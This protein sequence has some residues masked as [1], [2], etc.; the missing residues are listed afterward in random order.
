MS[1]RAEP[2]DSRLSHWFEG[3]A[4]REGHVPQLEDALIGGRFLLY[5]AYRLRFFA[6]R[7]AADTGVHVV[8][9]LF[10]YAI[11]R[12]S[13]LYAVV[14]TFAAAAIVESFWWGGL[15]VLRTRVRTLYQAG[16]PRQIPR[17]VGSWLSISAILS[18]IIA[19]GGAVWIVTSALTQR[20]G[21]TP[22]DLYMLSIVAGLAAAV[23]TRCYHSGI[24]AIRRIYRPFSVVI[25]VEVG[26]FALALALWPVVG[27]WSFPIAVTASTAISSA[28]VLRYTRRAYSFL[29]FHPEECMSLTG[30]ARLRGARREF[31]FA[32]LANTVLEMDSFL[33]LA[34][35]IA[36]GGLG[37]PLFVVFFAASPTV[38][39][40]ASWT[41][42]FYF[43]L[44]RL[45]IRLL[46]AI[47]RRFERRLCGLAVALG[48]AAWLVTCPIATLV[49]RGDLH[50]IYLPL[51]LFFV[52]RS[53]LATVQVAAFSQRAYGRVVAGGALLA[54]A[55][56]VVRLEALD[57][58]ATLLAIAAVAAATTLAMLTARFLPAVERSSTNTE[59]LCLS[60]W[61]AALTAVR[62]PVRVAV[63]RFAD[64]HQGLV[65]S[66]D[67]AKLRSAERRQVA[68]Q[69]ARRL[70][71]RGRVARLFPDGIVWYELG[72][73][74]T[75]V[76]DAW[77]IRRSAGTIS[78][79]R[80]REQHRDG[81][82]A[83]AAAVAAGFIDGAAGAPSGTMRPASVDDVSRVFVEL[84]P[85][86]AVYFNR[87]RRRHAAVKTMPPKASKRILGDALRFSRE[88]RRSS[89]GSRFDVTTLCT[90][91]GIE[92]IFVVDRQ[93]QP[94]PRSEW[95][96]FIR[97][98][99][100]AAALGQLPLKTAGR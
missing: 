69:V 8:R 75:F 42:L 1:I 5:A 12:Q 48:A 90:Q 18:A 58:V 94:G 62:G 92:R 22:A 78:S 23:V 96:R 39:A 64:H 10:L 100:F 19:L 31:V 93:G 17:V 33:V 79:I 81:A 60:T 36:A 95:H 2:T 4:A 83:A 71:R 38:R 72:A 3:R 50:L 45:D 70:G 11:F 30:H 56:L 40:A 73:E 98:A 86:G 51:L 34:L 63:A 65:R 6:A 46:G 54:A 41:K 26:G 82:A 80:R 13:Q 25:G 68:E 14:A 43:D 21:F 77:L 99:N 53:L 85:D 55:L 88:F 47:R 57:A 84:F 74:K 67:Q 7:Y 27:S 52:T 49:Y 76:D 89:D 35:V 59:P 24:Y 9:F 66:R 97:Q 37:S 28:V 44:K 87:N 29:D 20:R 15:E 61:L 91:G 16:N 32:G